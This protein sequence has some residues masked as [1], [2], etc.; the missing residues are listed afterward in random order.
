M[1]FLYD[2]ARADLARKQIQD[3]EDA[4]LKGLAKVPVSKHK[5]TGKGKDYKHKNGNAAADPTEVA[6][7]FK[8]AP[9]PKA[10]PLD[11]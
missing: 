7:K 10:N 8:G 6:A 11:L 4:S 1:Q 2:V 3:M 5:V 9:P